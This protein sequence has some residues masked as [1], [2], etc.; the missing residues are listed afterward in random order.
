[1]AV[2]VIPSALRHRTGGRERVL[3]E[4]SD[5][6][7]LFAELERHF[8]G[9]GDELRGSAIAIDGEIVNE[10]LLEPIEPDAE[11]HFVPRLGGG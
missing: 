2:A 6:R 8:P 5:V 7:K 3:V 9:L 10:P 4:A 11:V 1:M